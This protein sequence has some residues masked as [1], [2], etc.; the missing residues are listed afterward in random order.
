MAQPLTFEE[1]RNQAVQMFRN[2]PN[3][4]REQLLT[5]LRADPRLPPSLKDT[6]NKSAARVFAVMITR[7]KTAANFAQ[8]N[9]LLASVYLNDD[10]NLLT[11]D[12]VEPLYRLIHEKLLGLGQTP[13]ALAHLVPPDDVYWL[14]NYIDHE[15]YP[16]MARAAGLIIPVARATSA[17]VTGSQGGKRSSFSKRKSRKHRK[18]LKR[19]SRKHKAKKH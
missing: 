15:R 12:T 10:E 1:I 14:A 2:M 17:P 3:N 13:S 6:D 5:N 11:I 8:L 9:D 4:L 16:M 18:T 19:K 7:D